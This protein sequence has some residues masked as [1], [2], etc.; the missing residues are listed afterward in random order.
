MIGALGGA[1]VNYAFMDFQEIAKGHF[2][3][4]R[5]ERAYGKGDIREEYERIA[6][7]LGASLSECLS[8]SRTIVRQQLR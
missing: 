2:T 5:L 7:Q 3:V 6:K 8:I 4:R 1:V